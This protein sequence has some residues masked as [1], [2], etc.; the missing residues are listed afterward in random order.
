[1][2]KFL[3]LASFFAIGTFV[4]KGQGAGVQ[5]DLEAYH[6]TT[7]GWY[8]LEDYRIIVLDSAMPSG[9]SSTHEYYTDSNGEL[10]TVYYSTNQVGNI[11][12]YIVDCQSNW[13]HMGSAD[14]DIANGSSYPLIFD[15]V[16]VSCINPCEGAANVTSVNA[17]TST[18]EWVGHDSWGGNNAEWFFGDGTTMTGNLVTKAYSQSG[19]YGWHLEHNGCV[20][21]SGQVTVVVPNN[22]PCQADFEVDTVNSFG[23]QVII[24]NTSQGS[25]GTGITTEFTWFFGDG[26]S[27]NAAFPTHQY[28]SPGWY[29]LTLRMRE[30]DSNGNM[31]CETFRTDSVG[32]DSTGALLYK[33]GFTLKVMDPESIGLEEN[34]VSIRIYPQPSNGQVHVEAVSQIRSVTVM[35]V[36]GRILQNHNPES[37]ETIVDLRGNAAGL[38]LIR[39]ETESGSVIEKCLLQ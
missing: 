9:N 36:N 27:S 7:T 15:T 19:T 11:D 5:L 12:V 2:K 37:T 17:Y 21:D 14:Y 38:Y 28:Q 23:G 22:N 34:E 35:D 1:M 25:T 20:I 3:L 26:D 31:I 33:N 16:T 4:A 6:Q 8:G 24:W 13:T 30:F 32:M 18:F 10:N 29:S 39:V